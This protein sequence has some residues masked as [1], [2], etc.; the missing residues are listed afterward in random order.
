MNKLTRILYVDDSAFDREL[1]RD[2][3]EKEANGF[4]LVEAGS[5]AEFETAL[6]NERHAP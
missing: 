4:Q 3:I 5:R 1:V 6:A 2:A